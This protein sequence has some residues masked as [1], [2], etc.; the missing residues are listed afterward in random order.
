MN[1]VQ[2]FKTG[3]IRL[4][5]DVADNFSPKYYQRDDKKSWRM[6]VNHPDTSEGGYWRALPDNFNLDDFNIAADAADQLAKMGYARYE[7]I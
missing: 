1:T 2:V 3:E 7:S 6:W 5:V 4:S